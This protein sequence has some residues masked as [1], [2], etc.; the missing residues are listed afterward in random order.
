MLSDERVGD[1]R[2]RK[3]DAVGENER[4]TVVGGSGSKTREDE[5]IVRRRGRG[6]PVSIT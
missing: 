3:N 5:K 6:P 2:K 4:T 1:G